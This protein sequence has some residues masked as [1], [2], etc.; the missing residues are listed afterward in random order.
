MLR[1]L[2]EQLNQA[3]GAMFIENYRQRVRKAYP[4]QNDGKTILPFK[5]MFMVA[6][7]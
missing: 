3:E 4:P 1:P 2:L 6:V 7:K 5:R